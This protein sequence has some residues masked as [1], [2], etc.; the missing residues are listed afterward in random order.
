M[1][2]LKV[3]LPIYF[4]LF[5]LGGFRNIKMFLLLTGI[6]TMPFR[7]TYT[8]IDVGAYTGWTN[9]IVLSLSDVSFIGL[10]LYLLLTGRKFQGI[11]RSLVVPVMFMIGSV[12]LSLLNSTW[13]RLSLFEAVLL[14]QTFFLYY[15][16]FTSAIET[17][18]ELRF[19][20]MAL[21]ISLLLQGSLGILQCLT[22]REL[23]A[24][25]T[26][27]PTTEFIEGA[28]VTRALGTIGKPNG[29]AMYV[30]PII[31][32]V[33]AVLMKTKEKF[34]RPLGWLAVSTGGMA[35]LLSYSRGGWIAFSLALLVLIVVMVR[36]GYVEAR[37]P[38]AVLLI[39][40]AVAVVFFPQ[41]HDRLT[42]DEGAA[43]ATDRIYLIKI[44]WNMIK[45]SPLVGIGAN[46]FMSV[47]GQYQRGAEL[48]D[49]YLHMVHNQYL[50]VAAETGFVG[51][52]AFLWLLIACFRQA[53]ECARSKT[54]E[55][56][57]TV[58]LSAAAG[59]IAMTAH[60]MVD[61]YSSPLYLGMLFFFCGL[62]SAAR[63]V[64]AGDGVSVPNRHHALSPRFARISA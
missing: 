64:Q 18:K 12:I 1:N 59:F 52:I 56:A 5:V 16:V 36:G 58:G 63:K 27:T 49:I 26:G 3:I 44:A 45:E 51:I 11:S 10:F 35:L 47:I 46:T 48:Q 29:L 40:V 24:F 20:I 60:M 37:R 32:L 9:G 39:V 42:S 22:G 61:M 43:A 8:L 19:V 54:S 7:T 4:V 33:S 2:A 57:R 17:E 38:F 30:V 50:L 14:A 62:C 21:M 13:I 55:L 28:P 6:V 23:D 25:Q 53:L 15:I 34:Y 41:I 31:L